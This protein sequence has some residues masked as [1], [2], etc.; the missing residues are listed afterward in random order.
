MANDEGLRNGE[1][2]GANR[3]P[4]KIVF[5]PAKLCWSLVC[6]LYAL[7]LIG[8]S[9]IVV[10]KAP[11]PT[12]IAHDLVFILP[13][14]LSV[15]ILTA[16]LRFWDLL[17]ALSSRFPKNASIISGGFDAFNNRPQDVMLKILL[18]LWQPCVA[19]CNIYAIQARNKLDPELA[20]IALLDF[21]RTCNSALTVIYLLQ[22][23][24]LGYDCI[25]S[26][27]DDKA[28]QT[29]SVDEHVPKEE[30]S[31]HE[32]QARDIVTEET[33]VGD[34]LFVI[35]VPQQIQIEE[36]STF[37]P[38][39]VVIPIPELQLPKDD[40]I[41]A[42]SDVNDDSTGTPSNNAG[43]QAGG[44]GTARVFLEP[45]DKQADTDAA[46]YWD[47]DSSWSDLEEHIMGALESSEPGGGETPPDNP[48]DST[49]SKHPVVNGS[50]VPSVSTDKRLRVTKPLGSSAATDD[51]T[52]SP[53]SSSSYMPSSTVGVSKQADTLM[54]GRDLFNGVGDARNAKRRKLMP[55]STPVRPLVLN[56]SND[57]PQSASNTSVTVKKLIVKLKYRPPKLNLSTAEIN[58]NQS[59]IS[60]LENLPA[61]LR[62]R[63]YRFLDFPVQKSPLA[64]AMINKIPKDGPHLF[65][66]TPMQIH[67]GRQGTKCYVYEP[68]LDAENTRTGEYTRV[69]IKPFV[70]FMRVNKNIKDE[71][72]QLLYPGVV[73]S[74][75]WI[76]GAIPLGTY[77]PPSLCGKL[78]T[79]TV[80]PF[81]FNYAQ[82][83]N[84]PQL[85]VAGQVLN[86]APAAAPIPIPVPAVVTVPLPVPA[87]IPAPPAGVIS[88]PIPGMGPHIPPARV[89]N[90]PP[91][92]IMIP[93]PGSSMSASLPGPLSLL[94]TKIQVFQPVLALLASKCPHLSILI[95]CLSDIKVLGKPLLSIPIARQ[96]ALDWA[97]VFNLHI[98]RMG[99]LKTLL[100]GANEVVFERLELG[101]FE[102]ECRG[103]MVQDFLQRV[104]MGV[105]LEGKKGEVRGKWVD[106]PGAIVYTEEE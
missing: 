37:T 68:I 91:G 50:A 60:L 79:C 98:G 14:C 105:F 74:I 27:R 85:V 28:G 49:P 55:V 10:T 81:G 15:G 102:K 6:L 69:E 18:W 84:P 47:L 66:S 8:N 41:H 59:H 5:Q 4:Q 43:A 63:V 16:V 20:R 51:S 100:V 78:T 44:P 76:S 30:Q 48:I 46:D 67:I 2:N 83:T 86:P 65:H 77:L 45:F 3:E 36:N 12:P 53:S 38:P 33:S 1:P 94:H 104:F 21:M 90:Q 7:V 82:V 103:P 26:A 64:Y 32:L 95:I 29:S 88:F 40:S 9:Y 42:P 72:W 87:A 96:Q 23:V 35:D 57:P 56:K 93:L 61:E 80:G 25:G 70:P 73:Y 22:L 71:L 106:C 31:V 17:H 92:P 19:V 75:S 11:A 89:Q 99:S 52:T 101:R 24:W 58:N 97:Y 54:R 39:A 34:D 62:L 13:F